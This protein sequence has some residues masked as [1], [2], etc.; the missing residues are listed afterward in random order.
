MRSTWLGGAGT[1]LAV[2]VSV[3]AG[4][5]ATGNDTAREWPMY[6]GDLAGTG[7]SVMA[8]INVSN[9]G[10]LQRAWTYSLASSTDGA[11]G[12]NSQAT[13]IVVGDVMYTPSA[14]RVVAL[15]PMTGAQLW[16]HSVTDAA[17]SRRGVA[18]WSAKATRHPV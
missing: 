3:Q 13:P 18:Y 17:P 12:P 7:Y 2:I 6:R 14:D 16:S 1:A 10:A 11:R 8:E 4:C 5:S 15:D 9:V